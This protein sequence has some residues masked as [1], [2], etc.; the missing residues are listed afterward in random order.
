SWVA[1]APRPIALDAWRLRVDG[2]VK[3]PL[4]LTYEDVASAGD[5]L[6]ATLDCTSGFY[7]TQRWSGI[8]GGR[9][10]DRATPPAHAARV[11]FISVTGYRWTL[12]LAEA[13]NALLGMQVGEEMLAHEHG[14][15]VRLVAPGRRGFQW[16]KWV[17]RMEVR[18]APDPGEL[19]AIHTSS[20]TAA[21]RG[22]E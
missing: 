5:E 8:R 4:T 21:G 18:T 16:V 9:L 12:P 15:P 14:G 3:T 1:D 22:E 17:V 19:L 10:L 2:A 20:F 11:S 13:R 7:S 6:V